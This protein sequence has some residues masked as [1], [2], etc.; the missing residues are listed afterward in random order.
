MNRGRHNSK[1]TPGTIIT[2]FYRKYPRAKL[3]FIEQDL[4][5][6]LYY[7]KKCGNNPDLEIFISDYYRGYTSGGFNWDDTKEKY[8][9]W[10]K[11]MENFN[12]L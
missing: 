7:Q 2:N 9:Y 1:T 12:I 6:I 3:L 5:K 8:P 11:V 4:L 10:L